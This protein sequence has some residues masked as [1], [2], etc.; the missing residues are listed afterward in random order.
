MIFIV[1]LSEPAVKSKK[2]SFTP[3]YSSLQ[4]FMGKWAGP[5]GLYPEK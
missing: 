5:P 3:I 2:A 1:A 4:Q